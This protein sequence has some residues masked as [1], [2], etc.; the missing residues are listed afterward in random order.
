MVERIGCMLSAHISSRILSVFVAFYIHNDHIMKHMK[1]TE[2]NRKSYFLWK[3]DNGHQSPWTFLNFF[4]MGPAK[5]QIWHAIESLQIPVRH[6][7]EIWY[8]WWKLCLKEASNVLNLWAEMNLF[9]SFLLGQ[10]SISMA[11]LEKDLELKSK[12]IP[13]PRAQCLHFFKLILHSD[14]ILNL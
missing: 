11:I 6:G 10:R 12:R 3:G 9:F 13:K 7:C 1:P 2:G 8:S 14:L 5:Q 4:N